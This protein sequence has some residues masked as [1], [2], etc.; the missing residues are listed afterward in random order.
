MA[1]IGRHMQVVT[2]THLPQVAARGERHFKVYKI[3]EADSTHTHISL[4]D[5]EQRRAELS[6][7]LSGNPSD[8]AALA[9]AENLLKNQD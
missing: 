9:A 1:E 6:L 2:I 4:L 7:M 8:P 3:D 5:T